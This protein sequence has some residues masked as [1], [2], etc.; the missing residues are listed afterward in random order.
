MKILS[1]NTWGSCLRP[2]IYDFIAQ[3]Q[4]SVDVFCFQELY[5]CEHEERA[6]KRK[7]QSIDP[8]SFLALQAQLDNHTGHFIATQRDDEGLGIFIRKEYEYE[9]QYDIAFSVAE[10]RPESHVEELDRPVQGISLKIDSTKEFSI[11]NFHGLWT[12]HG[13]GDVP[14]RHDQS[15]NLR[16]FMERFPR[17]WVLCGD[18]NLN[19]DTDSIA[20][21]SEG[22]RDLVNEYGVT[23]TR[24]SYYP[25]NNPYADYMFVSPELTVTD[26]RVL[27][28]EISDHLP[29]LIEVAYN[30]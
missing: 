23:T 3:W 7:H 20:V 1:L 12:G 26:F 15:R 24:S 21:A 30:G 11:F 10:I 13:K 22:M 8:Q 9:Y 4:G 18:F 25:K 6:V 16:A 19:P 5:W 27:P 14:E 2:Q 29:L 28:D 17:P